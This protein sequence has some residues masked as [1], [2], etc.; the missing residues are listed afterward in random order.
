M[1][2]AI[3]NPCSLKIQTTGGPHVAGRHGVGA[4]FVKSFF[5]EMGP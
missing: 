1:D 5:E 2:S 4:E 3:G